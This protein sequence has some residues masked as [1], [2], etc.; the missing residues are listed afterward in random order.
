MPDHLGGGQST[1]VWRVPSRP[2]VLFKRYS[3]EYVRT[4]SAAT[5]DHLI[6][7]PH[8]LRDERDRDL[9]G[10]STSWPVERVVHE[11]QTVGVLLR[12]VPDRFTVSW[13]SPRGRQEMQTTL[14]L[15]FLAKPNAYLIDRRITEQHSAQR[16]RICAR[17]AAIAALLERQE[18]VYADWSYSNAF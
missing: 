9:L 17:L 15:D 14:L 2:G 5:L 1:G 8:T 12:E 18:I 7:L 13:F 6:A 10:T 3:E 4:V 16:E 11:G